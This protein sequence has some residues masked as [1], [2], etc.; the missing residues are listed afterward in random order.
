[1]IEALQTI[2]KTCKRNGKR[3]ALHCGSAE[4]AARAIGWGYDMTTVS[5]DARLLASAA[6]ASVKA[7]RAAVSDAQM[8]GT[9]NK[10]SY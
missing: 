4:Y 7:F 1:M 5:G 3:A 9:D 2:A 8:D 6:A 10:G